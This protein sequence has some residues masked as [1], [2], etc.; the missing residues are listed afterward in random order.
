MKA[1][2]IGAGLAG[3]EAA[4]Q[5]ARR[6]VAVTLWAM[7]PRK[8]FPAPKWTQAGARSVSARI[9]SQRKPGRRTP[10]CSQAAR[11]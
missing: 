1:T 8:M 9:S 2:V 11:S 7:K 6:G 10:A 3:S 5:L 4:W